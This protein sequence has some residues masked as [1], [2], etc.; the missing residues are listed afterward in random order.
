MYLFKLHPEDMLECI[1][2]E[3]ANSA[4]DVGFLVNLIIVLL[5]YL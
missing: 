5:W 3:M 1:I 2:C 4:T